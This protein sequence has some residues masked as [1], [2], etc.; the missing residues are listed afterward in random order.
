MV[1]RVTVEAPAHL[2]AG[3]IDLRGDLGR[4]YGTVGL[5]IDY[6]KTVIEVSMSDRLELRGKGADYAKT[7]IEKLSEIYGTM[8]KAR[9]NI[10]TTVP[11]YLGLG[12]RTSLALSVASALTKLYEIDASLE[13]LALKLGRGKVS[14]LGVY[15]FKLGGF[16]I[17]GGFKVGMLEKKIPPLIFRAEIPDDWWFIV[18]IPKGPVKTIL[19]K[20]AKEDEV[21]SSLKRM[22][23]DIVKELSRIVLMGIMPSIR[24]RDIA[25]FGRSMMDFNAKLG[26]F[27]KDYQNGIYCDPIVESGI[28]LMVKKGAYGACQS[29]WGPT[30]YGIVDK[31]TLAR[32]ISDVLQNYFSD[33]GGCDVFLTK[34]NNK[35]AKISS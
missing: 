1:L 3:N 4:L 27:W 31:E 28:K 9:I 19:E 17:D 16:I 10:L 15:S 30:F 25:S 12:F 7:C 23:E 18:C 5:T 13:D 34:A 11:A 32:N 24:E 22:D 29:S 21:L 8:F 6:P 26:E 35:G 14:A 20:K 33:K 2:H